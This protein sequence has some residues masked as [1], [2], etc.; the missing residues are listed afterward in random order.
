MIANVYRQY[1]G[2]VCGGVS[3]GFFFGGGGLCWRNWRIAGGV[4]VFGAVRGRLVPRGLKG[5]LKLIA[6]RRHKWIRDM[7]LVSCTVRAY[8]VRKFCGRKA[9][10]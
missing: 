4:G 6:I 1:G 10:L 9:Q 5:I 8:R 7:L 3:I 2:E